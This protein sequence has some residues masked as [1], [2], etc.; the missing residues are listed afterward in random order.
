MDRIEYEE[1]SLKAIDTE[2]APPS[3][4]LGNGTEG[5]EDGKVT[6]LYPPSLLSPGP[7][8]DSLK[9]QLNHREPHHKNAMYKCLVFVL[10]SLS[11]S[12]WELLK[13]TDFGDTEELL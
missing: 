8:L 5:G 10:P 9:S 13:F 7:L 2:L 6:L 1:W 4:S 11:I 3:W 12:L